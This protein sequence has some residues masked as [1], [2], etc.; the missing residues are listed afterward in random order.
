MTAMRPEPASRR[1][2]ATTAAV[3]LAFLSVLL[4][5]CSPL[6]RVRSRLDLPAS[7]GS[8]DRQKLH[9][10]F[11]ASTAAGPLAAP[12]PGIEPP[13]QRLLAEVEVTPAASGFDVELKF[14]KRSVYVNLTGWY[15]S[16]GDGKVNAGDAVG[17]LGPAPVL[18]TDKGVF[19]GNLTVT[20]PIELKPVL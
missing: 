3:G 7:V 9:V 8:P 6:A 1:S 10:T 4:V 5:S 17:S 13:E 2:E 19:S 16:N 14:R 18:A 15:D 12:P 20:P 11:A